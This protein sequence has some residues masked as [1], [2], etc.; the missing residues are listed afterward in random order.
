MTISLAYSHYNR[1]QKII[2]FY[3]FLQMPFELF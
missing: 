3:F 1:C 2:F